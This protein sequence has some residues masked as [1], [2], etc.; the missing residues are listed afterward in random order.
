MWNNGLVERLSLI[1]NGAHINGKKWKDATLTFY[2]S[3]PHLMDIYR[4]TEETSIRRLKDMYHEEI[5]RVCQT[6]GWKDY[7]QVNLSAYDGDLGLVE[8]KMRQII[9]EQDE[10]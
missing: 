9:Q 4:S 7:Y 5:K 10:N 1:S 8:A 6:N 2:M 3:M